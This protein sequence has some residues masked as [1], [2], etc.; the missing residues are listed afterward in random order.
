MLAN[1]A[2]FLCPL[3]TLMT[4]WFWSSKKTQAGGIFNGGPTSSVTTREM[5]GVIG[6]ILDS[7]SS[8]CRMIT[9]RKDSEL[10]SVRFLNADNQE[11][12]AKAKSQLDWIPRDRNYPGYQDCSISD[13]MD[14]R[15]AG[16]VME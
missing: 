14:I 15:A 10:S 1:A 5:P 12:G 11:P 6:P 13:R 4:P 7:Q 9:P 3:P 2:E 8:L 16:S